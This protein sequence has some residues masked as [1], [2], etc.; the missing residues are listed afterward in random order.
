MSLASPLVPPSLSDDDIHYPAEDGEPMA[1]TQIHIRAIILLFQALE[2]F[3]ARCLDIYIAADMFW[4][5]EKGNVGA[6]RAPDVMVIKGVGRRVRRSF[7]SW[8]ENEAVPCVIFEMASEGTW[9]E[10]LNEKRRVYEALGVNEYFVFDP[11]ALYLQP[12]LQG[13]RRGEDGKFVPLQYDVD[14]QLH[15]EELGI[16]LRPEG[17][18]LRVLDA[19]TGNPVLLRTERAE[20]EAQ[21]ANE[22]K[23]QADVANKRADA[24]K[25]RAD[26]EKK[27]ADAEKKRA[28]AEK[29]QTD[30]ERKRADNLE[31]ELARLKAL[32]EKNGG[33]NPTS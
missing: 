31:R 17:E 26:A 18:F 5:W 20:K 16:I 8:K 22:E 2:D 11:E 19:Q 12:V 13:F 4:Y 27:R 7:L 21:R 32:Y 30:T 28:D 24:E 25:K 9:R 6:R 33:A 14:N 23:K 1:E 10:N 29:K 3:L 15:C